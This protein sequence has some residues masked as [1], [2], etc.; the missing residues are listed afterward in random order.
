MAAD[1]IESGKAYL[2]TPKLGGLANNTTIQTEKKELLYNLSTKMLAITGRQYI[3]TDAAGN[4]V[5]R[6]E[7]DHTIIFPRHRLI[8]AGK[9]VATMGQAGIIP[10]KYSIEIKNMPRAEVHIGSLSP[11]SKLKTDSSVI[12]EIAQHRS[13]WITVLHT[14]A[15]AALLLMAIAILSRENTIGG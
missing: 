10:Q 9:V 7:Q 2:I 13:T 1:H 12:A 3:I 11:V 15:H 14:E 8:R 6:T 4:E 5:L